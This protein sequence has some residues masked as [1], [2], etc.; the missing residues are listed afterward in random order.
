LRKY[1]SAVVLVFFIWVGNAQI[2]NQPIAPTNP[3]GIKILHSDFIDKNQNEIPGAI[4]FT[5]NVQVQHNGVLINCNKAYHYTDE[6]YV[7][8]F[9]N[10]ILN[11]GDTIVMNS[12]YAEYNGKTLQAFA[13]GNV[14]LRSPDS[15]LTTDTIYFDRNKQEA[16]YRSWGT[17][18]NK[19]NT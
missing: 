2:I 12:R 10:V 4:I 3:N 7:K 18:L 14:N 9:G 6:D 8:A 19:E 1:K 15:N 11:Q 17:I 13:T 5:G 16:F